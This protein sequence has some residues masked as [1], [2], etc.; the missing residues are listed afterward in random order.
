MIPWEIIKNL[1]ID[2]NKLHSLILSIKTETHGEYDNEMY[3]I[4]HDATLEWLWKGPY[5]L[6]YSSLWILEEKWITSNDFIQFEEELVNSIEKWWDFYLSNAWKQFFNSPH[7][8]IEEIKKRPVEVISYSKTLIKQNIT[9]ED[10]V[11]KID[12]FLEARRLF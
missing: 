9:F 6:L 7:N 12:E 10:F 8:S 2:I 11:K 3:K 4:I 1:D 5:Y